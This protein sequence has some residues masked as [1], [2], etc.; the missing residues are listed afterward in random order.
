MVSICHLLF[1]TNNH[2]PLLHLLRAY[3]LLQI[4]E[5]F[6]LPLLISPNRSSSCA[7]YECS[8]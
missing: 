4:C 6:C 5:E 3:H 2:K 7:M 8:P 1:L